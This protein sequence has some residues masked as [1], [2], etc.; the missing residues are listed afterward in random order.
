VGDR[1]RRRPAGQL[2]DEVLATLWASDEALT[3]GQVQQRIADRSL[4]YTTVLTILARLFDKGVVERERAGRAY[5]YRPVLDR[6]GLAARQMRALLDRT[7]DR[8]DVLARF[9]SGLSADDERVLADL[10][11]D[12]TGG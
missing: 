9:V 3:P 5:A 2:E 7:G 1:R 6:A 11:R 12:E 8:T 10:L 4:A